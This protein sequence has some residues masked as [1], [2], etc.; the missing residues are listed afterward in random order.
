M[1]GLDVKYA[2]YKIELIHRVCIKIRYVHISE[3][4]SH[5]EEKLNNSSMAF[6]SIIILLS[7]P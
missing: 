2:S 5:S 3:N 7:L 1:E 6:Q 4:E